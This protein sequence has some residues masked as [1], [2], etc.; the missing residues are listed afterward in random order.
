MNK[1][2]TMDAA[3]RK[4]LWNGMNWIRQEKRLAIYL[5]DSMA[6]VYCSTGVEDGAQLTLDHVVAVEKGGNN[7][8]ENLVTACDRCNNAKGDRNMAEFVR[9]TAAYLNQGVTAFEI[10]K[11]VL[12]CMSRTLPLEYAKLMIAQR[13]S[14]AKAVAAHREAHTKQQ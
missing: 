12:D 6:C 7:G 14:A 3:T 1:A 2:T 10:H 4:K 11:H 8:A 13:G 5:R 9:A